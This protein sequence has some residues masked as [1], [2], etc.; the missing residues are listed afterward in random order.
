M[1]GK[2]LFPHQVEAVDA[3]LRALQTPASGHM[4]AEGLRTQVIAATGS[5]KTLIAAEAAQKLAARRVLVLVPT[6]DLL[7]QTAA[8]WREAGR[9]G[10]VLG[11]CRLPAKDSD[12]VPCT[13]DSAELVAWAQGLEQ[14]TVFA[15]YA[16][17]GLGILQRAHAQGLGVWDL[18]VV[19]EAHRTSGDAGKPWAGVHD[20][21]KIPA[22]RRLYMTATARVWEAAGSGR[23][24]EPRLIA[25][26]DPD[27][28][29]FGPVAFK[30][31]L[32]EAISR[33][34]VAPYQVVCVD[35]T[36][37][38]LHQ[39][40]E[41]AASPGS[42]AVR[43]ARLAALQTGIL[44]AAAQERLRKVLTFHSMVTEAEAMAEGVVDVAQRLW[45]DD[46]RRF[47]APER[48]W[49]DWLYGDHAP[50]HRRAVLD[51]FAS[52]VIE[53][54]GGLRPA[55]LR[56]LS[57][58]KVLG[59]G[60]DTANCDSVAF[61]DARGS[62]V[63]IVQMVGRAL[64]MKPGEGKIASLI[65]PVFLM[66]GESPDEMLT[67][68]AYG[69]LAKVLGALRAHDTDTI[70]ALAD[71]RVRSGS[72]EPEEAG[73]EVQ[74]RPEGEQGPSAPAR[75]LLK[76][77]TPRDPALLAR[78]VKLRVIE[79]EN[80]FW[81]RGIEAAVRYVKE[82]GAEQLRVP[83]DFVTPPEWSP[84][85]FPLGTWLADQRRFNKAGRLAPARAAELDGLGIVW[86]HQDVAFE[87]GLAAAR[88]WA[89][90]HG[91]FLPP[92]TAVWDGHPVGIWA[93]NMRTAARL[94]DTIAERRQA[95][96]PVESSAKALTEA[97]REALD[98]IDPGWCPAWDTRWQRC[99][100]LAQAHVEDGGAVPTV[101]GEAT[102][103]GEDLGRWV[104]GCRLGWDT[105]LPVQQWLLE[106]I[107]GLTPAEED[108]R[109]VKRTQDDR[110]ALNLRAAQQFHAREGHLNVPRKHVEHLE[111]EGGPMGPQRDAEELPAVKLGMVLD[112]IRKRADKLTEQR[113]TELNALGMRW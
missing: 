6:L 8:A 74:E 32:S 82:T 22:T 105:L 41:Q 23:D 33:G 71:P 85:G 60:V 38:E 66:P 52:D 93:K 20:Q 5:G 18:M 63:D 61:C 102:V 30:L 45:Q 36:D 113:R 73:E 64:R 59:E 4:P 101:A 89:E 34:L 27:S 15:T 109:P 17:V 54:E 42:D 50:G 80:A 95:G 26:M 72:Y 98:E 3:V 21:A 46:P 88:A 86:S 37:P 78:F 70:E 53:D 58:V 10:T 76:F 12:G 97:R 100:R 9:T 35:I 19:D 81:R 83:Y 87:E 7:T 31:T 44:T 92:A 96:L 79:P 104:T 94:A 11:V 43:G 84:A 103:Q 28:A 107:L 2:E 106:N 99:F 51:E 69:T 67:S 1:P 62:M 14:V 13:T 48:V 108:E 25:S 24:E 57:S 75:E 68:P 39:A 90:V 77:S 110:W 16:A 112:N 65:V 47:P 55:A 111:P 29:V 91:H 56:V 49:A 40:H